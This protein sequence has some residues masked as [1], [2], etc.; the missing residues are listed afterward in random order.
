MTRVLIAAILVAAAVA[1]A[2]W[3]QRRRPAP[4]KAPSFHVPERLDR[5]D[6]DGRSAPWLVVAFTS[7]T[8]DTCAAVAEKVR[9]LASDAVA[10]QEVEVRAA[11]E[12]H[13]RYGVDAVPLVVLADDRGTVRAHWFGPV[14]ASE[15]W[16][17]VAA[18][19]GDG[20]PP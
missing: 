16:S 14:S 11:K 15:L 8:C 20:H 12:L 17:T 9:A 6:F 13:D 19:R 2:W 4:A 1:V 10:V 7:A 18:V 3:L 5:A